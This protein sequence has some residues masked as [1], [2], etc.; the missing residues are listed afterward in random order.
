MTLL[1]FGQM[2]TV[3][4]WLSADQRTVNR[5][6]VGQKMEKEAQ[7]RIIGD[8]FDTSTFGMPLFLPSLVESSQISVHDHLYIDHKS[9][10]II[11]EPGI[12]FYRNILCGNSVGKLFI[13]D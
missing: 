13:Q 1:L 11:T 6:L 8:V 10:R 9:L 12:D 3:R 4:E 7:R 2:K 5:Q